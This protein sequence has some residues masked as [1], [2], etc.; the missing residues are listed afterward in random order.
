VG[1]GDRAELAAHRAQVAT[2]L[3]VESFQQALLQGSDLV[4]ERAGGSAQVLL[5]GAP[6]RGGEEVRL[7]LEQEVQA[8]PGDACRDPQFGVAERAPWGGARARGALGRDLVAVS[9]ELPVG[10][11]PMD[12]IVVPVHEGSAS[13]IAW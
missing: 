7:G 9:H 12:G 6:D 2:G 3:G 11:Y 1:L 13:A 4:A 8:G 10:E 5:E